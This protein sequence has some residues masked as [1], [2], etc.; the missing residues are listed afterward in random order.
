MPYIF[1]KNYFH[2]TATFFLALF[3]LSNPLIA[4]ESG[5]DIM[6]DVRAQSRIH[7]TSQYE[8]YMIIENK[9]GQKRKRYFNIKKKIVQTISNTLIKFYKPSSVKGTGLLT[10]SNEKTSSNKQ[11]I[12]LPSLRSIQQLRS[13]DKNQSFMGSDFTNAD[14]AG[15]ELNKDTHELKKTDAGYAYIESIPKDPEDPYSKLEIKVHRKNKVITEILFYDKKGKKLKVL[16]NKKFNKFKGMYV[17][18][19]AV[20]ENLKSQGKTTLNVSKAK[21]GHKIPDNA[22]A[23]RGLQSR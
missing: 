5:Y 6:K 12:Y 20:M 4:K 7:K 2:I 11:W 10:I 9:S 23:I 18:T 8:V 19:L 17:V 13:Q 22:V 1:F 3:L 21:V 16:Q 15:R 14:I